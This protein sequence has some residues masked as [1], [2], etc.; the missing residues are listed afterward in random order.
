M[1]LDIIA[2]K[3]IKE[4]KK[5]TDEAEQAENKLID[6]AGPDDVIAWDSINYPKV[7]WSYVQDLKMGLKE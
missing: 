1:G 5:Q 6:E 3:N 7:E 4:Y 2:V